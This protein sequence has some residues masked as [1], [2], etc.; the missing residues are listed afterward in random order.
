[1]KPGQQLGTDGITV[2]RN[3]AFTDGPFGESKERI[4]GYWFILAP[5][6]KEAAQIAAKSEDCRALWGV[7]GSAILDGIAYSGLLGPNPEAGLN[8]PRRRSALRL[9]WCPPEKRLE[10]RAVQ[11]AGA[12]AT[13]P[14]QHPIPR[15]K[16]R[17]IR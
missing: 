14:R 11:E 15:A 3:E 2:P 1:M 8:T 17:R 5:G 4:E 9:H 12:A 16:R 10:A 7:S 6:L 13:P